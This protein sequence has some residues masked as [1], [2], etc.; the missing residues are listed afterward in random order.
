MRGLFERHWPLAA[1]VLGLWL[2]L[3]VLLHLSMRRTGG[4]FVYP[5]D[6]T[7]ISMA[8][9]KNLA[10]HGVWGVTRHGFTSSSSSLLW[11]LVLAASCLLFGSNEVT[12]LAWN[13]VL[14]TA[15]LCMAYGHLKAQGLPPTLLFV[16][17]EAVA[18][19]TPLPSLILSGLE[20]TLHVLLTLAFAGLIA[21]D[22]SGNAGVRGR[23]PSPL[24]LLLTILLVMTRYEGLFLVLVV[25]GLSTLGRRYLY[26]VLLGLMSLVPPVIYGC[27]SVVHGWYPIP[28]SVLLKGTLG[29]ILMTIKSSAPMSEPFFRGIAAL[30]GLAAYKNL[31]SAP[32]MLFLLAVSLTVYVALSTE[33]QAWC[34]GSITTWLFA[35]AALLHMQFGRT[36]WL[37]RY[38]AYLVALG[39][40]AV[41]LSLSHGLPRLELGPM[42]AAALPRYAAMGLLAL[43]PAI[44]LIERGVAATVRVVQATKNIYEQQY[45][46]GLFLRDYYQGETV[47][48]H[49]IGAINYLADIRCVEVVGLANMEAARLN[50][51]WKAIAEEGARLSRGEGIAVIYDQWLESHGGVPSAWVKVGSW[52]I[53]GNVIAGEDTVSFYAVDRAKT[54]RL[55]ESLREF[56]R[57]LPGSVRQTGR[58]ALRSDVRW[59]RREGRGVSPGPASEVCVL[60]ARARTPFG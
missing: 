41:T 56:S 42:R 29:P 21:N 31:L 50:M 11:P 8:M 30:F 48:A 58:Y 22:L 45:Q 52:T 40:L 59:G 17:L 28:N 24:L 51:E 37:Y 47:T 19:L 20:H 6:D 12:P 34:R 3:A 18:F 49:D 33:K 36:G 23:A 5:L 7:Y 14:G 10:E 4:H 13:I 46:M 57:R 60:G 26:A 44:A 39:L 32:H 54:G 38:E 16:S 53:E 9:A 27:L 25:C 35:G 43:L 15:V 2:V 1:A 55:I